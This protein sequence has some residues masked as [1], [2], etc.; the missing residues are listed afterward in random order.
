MIGFEAIS[1]N[2]L[3]QTRRSKQVNAGFVLF[4]GSSRSEVTDVLTKEFAPMRIV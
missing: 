3:A 1:A 2:V 4:T